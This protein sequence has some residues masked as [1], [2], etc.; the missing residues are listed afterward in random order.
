VSISG[1][2][3]FDG[4]GWRDGGEVLGMLLLPLSGIG[5]DGLQVEVEV[6]GDPLSGFADFL[7]GVLF[8]YLVHRNPMSSSGVQTTGQE[9]PHA[10]MVF[11]RSEATGHCSS[12]CNSMSEKNRLRQ[13]MR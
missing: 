11:Q 10:E 3:F 4:G 9:Y 8:G 7:A 2:L 5:H 1:W 12:E 6:L 13:G